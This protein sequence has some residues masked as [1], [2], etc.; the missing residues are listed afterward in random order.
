M[1]ELRNI[2]VEL[3]R[4]KQRTWVAG[5]L[6]LVAFGLLSL[7]LVTLQVLRH[8]RLSE[9]AESNRTT[10]VPVVPH[11]GWILD[12]NGVVLASNY[13][14]YTLE[15]TPVE[16]GSDNMDELIAELAKIVRIEPRD[17]RRF[18]KLL[19]E[20]KNF[21]SIPLRS[22]LNDEEVARLTA[23]RYRFP[24]VEIQARLFRSYPLGETASHVVGYIGRINQ[25]EKEMLAD[26]EPGIQANYKGT[27]YIGK[28][29]IEQSFEKNLHGQAGVEQVETSAGGRATRQLGATQAKPGDGNRR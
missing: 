2:N 20:S 27:D 23:Q 7:R 22:R 24:G 15:I 5:A 26:M 21:E 19:G 12:R 13:S 9:Q 29:G 16:T 3:R 17:I 25:Q 1:T 14:A 11:R 28:L 6:V 18:K 8:E 10:I 4:F